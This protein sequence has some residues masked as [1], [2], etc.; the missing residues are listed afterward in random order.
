MR[1]KN[2]PLSPTDVLISG[3]KSSSVKLREIVVAAA[4]SEGAMTSKEDAERAWGAALATGEAAVEALLKAGRL[5]DET[6]VRWS[7]EGFCTL[8]V[9]MTPLAVSIELDDAKMAKMLLERGADPFKLEGLAKSSPP[10]GARSMLYRA[11]SIRV[12]SLLEPVLGDD[13]KKELPGFAACSF[14]GEYSDSRERLAWIV[15]KGLAPSD[16]IPHRPGARVRPNNQSAPAEKSLMETILSTG[17]LDLLKAVLKGNLRSSVS[18]LAR[19]KEVAAYCLWRETAGVR[20]NLGEVSAILT[21]LAKTG[22]ED[23]CLSL[24]KA[25]S[26]KAMTIRDQRESAES[27]AMMCAIM[28][29]KGVFGKQGEAAVKDGSAEWVLSAKTR[30]VAGIFCIVESWIL[31]SVPSEKNE[32]PLRRKI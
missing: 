32:T 21:I 23:S 26:E 19:L 11:R 8:G 28:A 3:L 13:F 1:E 17:R 27:F 30:G 9:S 16:V 2:T 18:E 4:L 5:P 10:R 6:T 22:G 14:A 12:A 29:E 24:L 25:I 20:K 31:A 15:S 7:S